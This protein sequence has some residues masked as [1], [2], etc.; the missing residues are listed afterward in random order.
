[1][2][3]LKWFCFILVCLDSIGYVFSQITREKPKNVTSAIS[4]VFGLIIGI[5]ARVFA[6]YGTAT[7]W[8]LV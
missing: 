6:L 8:L 5:L 7:C 3:I 2:K 4:R 1:M